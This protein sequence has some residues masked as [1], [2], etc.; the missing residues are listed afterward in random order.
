MFNRQY[1]LSIV[2]QPPHPVFS[3]GSVY[4]SARPVSDNGLD[5]MRRIEELHLDYRSAGGRILQGLLNG[6][7]LR[8]GR[9]HVATLMRNMV[10]IALLIHHLDRAFFDSK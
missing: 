6:E 8:V 10:V 4:Y 3:R 2:R 5:R 1:K 9:H 7:R